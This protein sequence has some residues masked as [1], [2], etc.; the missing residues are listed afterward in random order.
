MQV[1]IRYMAQLKRAADTNSETLEV[2]DQ[3]TVQSLLVRLTR[4]HPDLERM[5]LNDGQ[6]QP[7]ILVFVG[8]DQ[9]DDPQAQTL[10]EGDVVTLLSP[11]AGG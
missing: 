3:S 9:V 10:S 1:T 6:L 5:L 2:D 11:I 7:T 4:E 8:D